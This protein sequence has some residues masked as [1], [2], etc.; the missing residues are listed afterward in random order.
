M[1]LDFIVEYQAHLYIILTVLLAVGLYW[2]IF[3]LYRS[4]KIGRKNY[5]KYADIALHDEVYDTPVESIKNKNNKGEQ[6]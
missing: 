2:Y 5:E 4:E 1:I 3:H 6:K